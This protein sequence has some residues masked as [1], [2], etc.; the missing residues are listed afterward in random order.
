ML[1]QVTI[2]LQQLFITLLA[3]LGK[4]IYVVCKNEKNIK[5]Q[6]SLY[7]FYNLIVVNKKLW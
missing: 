5:D 3:L 2:T 1:K 7:G 6:R 4:Y